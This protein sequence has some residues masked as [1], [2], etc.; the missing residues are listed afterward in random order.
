MMAGIT[1][2]TQRTLTAAWLYPPVAAAH[3]HLVE[4]HV[5]CAFNE[6]FANRAQAVDTQRNINAL[7]SRVLAAYPDRHYDYRAHDDAIGRIR[8]GRWHVVGDCPIH[9]AMPLLGW[10]LLDQDEWA[11]EV[12][13]C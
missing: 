1:P 11:Q 4:T 10:P 9:G 2:F 12:S 5:I 6:Q 8:L 13:P 3:C 7:L